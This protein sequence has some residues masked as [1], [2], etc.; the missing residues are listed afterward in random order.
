MCGCLFFHNRKHWRED[1]LI[2]LSLYS[3][4]M[5]SRI[6]KC[7]ALYKLKNKGPF[8][9]LKNGQVFNIC[10]GQSVFFFNVNVNMIIHQPFSSLL[11]AW[12]PFCPIF[13]LPTSIRL[14]TSFG[15]SSPK[16]FQKYRHCLMMM[17][18]LRVH[19]FKILYLVLSLS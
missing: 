15:S 4:T 9:A 14:K 8:I 12:L 17:A 2:C 7:L 11:F 13:L 18:C 10:S 1:F 16:S 6:Q 5:E 19:N 3:L